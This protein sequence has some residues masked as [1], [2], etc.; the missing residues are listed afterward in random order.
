MNKE[1]KQIVRYNPSI[2][3]GLDD[4]QIKERLE[5]KLI[6]KVKNIF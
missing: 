1:P 5:N 2:E 3:N 4:N 6:N